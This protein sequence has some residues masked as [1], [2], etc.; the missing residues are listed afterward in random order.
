MVAGG[1]FHSPWHAVAP[2]AKATLSLS[3]ADP[4][5]K[6]MN[7]KIIVL[8]SLTLLATLPAQ[9]PDTASSDEITLEGGE[10]IE[11][12]SSNGKFEPVT[13]EPSARSDVALLFPASLASTSV[14]VQ[15]LDGGQLGIDG[16]S[17]TIDQNGML[18]FPFQVTD[19]P[20]VYRVVVIN[21]NADED[22]PVIVGVV[23]FE[24]PSPED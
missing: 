14:V 21:P 10:I 16:N 6:P 7:I 5:I 13:V 9:E 22:S 11:D 12:K 4:R 23:Q 17:A 2:S 19:Q 8:L 20:G 24:V 1:P 15:A 18:S 3:V